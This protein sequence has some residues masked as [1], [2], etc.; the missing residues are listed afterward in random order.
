MKSK[1]INIFE[2][3]IEKL[4]FLVMVLVLLAV[5][6]KQFALGGMTVKVGSRDGQSIT[7]AYERISEDALQIEGQIKA[8]EL[9]IRA[10][11]DAPGVDDLFSAL[12]GSDEGTERLTTWGLPTGADSLDTPIRN[13]GSDG[14]RYA[15][16][17][18]PAPEQPLTRR[19]AGA[20]D[21]AALAMAPGLEDYLPPSQPYDLQFTTVS[22]E[23]D[24]EALRRAFS[25]DPDGSGPAQAM[26]RHWWQGQ[27]VLLDVELWRRRVDTESSEEL[28]ASMPGFSEVRKRLTDGAV[29]MQE[30]LEIATNASDAVTR[31]E[32]YPII[33]GE[34]W[35]PPAAPIQRSPE[36]LESFTRRAQ[37][38]RLSQEIEDANNARN[39]LT[40]NTSKR[41]RKDDGADEMKNA[42]VSARGGGG[43]GGRPSGRNS[44]PA[45][46]TPEQRQAE[47]REKSIAA[48]QEKIDRLTDDRNEILDWFT[49]K[50]IDPES[51]IEEDPGQRLLDEPAG[52]LKESDRLTVWASDISVV[53]GATYEYR[54]RLVYGNPFYGRG[55]VLA[56]DQRSELSD[57]R[58]I[59]SAFSPWSDP[60]EIDQQSYF[61]LTRAG[62]SGGVLDVGNTASASAE[63]YSFYYGYW[64]KA[65]LRLRAGD[66]ILAEYE[67]P[68]LNRFEMADLGQGGN[69]EFAAIPLESTL[70]REMDTLLL[71]I[72]PSARVRRDALKGGR[73]DA[74][75]YEVVILDAENEID[76]RQPESDR[77]SERRRRLKDSANLAADA[78]IA[79]PGAGGVGGIEA[80]RSIDRTDRTGGPEDRSSDRNFPSREER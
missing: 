9:D 15:M 37:L 4:F 70:V 12:A 36:E 3:H 32:F 76:V 23:F 18:Q 38:D 6:V 51:I 80:P 49:D 28:V 69:D 22:A 72:R 17:D 39:E 71:D 8:D 56:E 52:S 50:G 30:I 19:Y 29:N 66:P 74:E 10:P 64:R 45:T 21:P 26:P 63:V 43:R 68:E 2:R 24:A 35:T 25:E 54:I 55:N 58:V 16:P 44:R 11:S 73:A 31:P 5:L 33:A 41:S 7:Q 77:I 62:L 40:G 60:V 48:I 47:S 78:V 53:P 57:A 75:L 27:L 1:S 42:W 67:L 79:E 14:V 20:I 61:F 13:P 46:K 65:E 59:R 34:Q